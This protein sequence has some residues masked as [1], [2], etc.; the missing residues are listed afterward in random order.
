MARALLIMLIMAERAVSFSSTTHIARRARTAAARAPRARADVRRRAGDDAE[1]CDVFDPTPECL[2][3][4]ES[5]GCTTE[6]ACRFSVGERVRVVTDTIVYHYPKKKD[7]L[8]TNGMVGTVIAIA[9]VVPGSTATISAN[10]PL[11][12]KLEDVPLSAHFEE[13]ELEPV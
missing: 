9:T 10:R 6:E 5:M 4:A 12:V 2:S 7:G 11:Q 1:E 13:G 8:N 3:E